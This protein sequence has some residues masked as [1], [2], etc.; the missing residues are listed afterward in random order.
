VWRY[1]SP[2][3]TEVMCYFLYTA[4]QAETLYSGD[5]CELKFIH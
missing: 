4:P 1:Q 2:I 3:F 5:S